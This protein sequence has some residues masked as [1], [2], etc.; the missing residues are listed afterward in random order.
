MEVQEARPH[1]EPLMPVPSGPLA[2]QIRTAIE[3]A[4]EVEAWLLMTEEARSDRTPNARPSLGRYVPS[5]PGSHAR[6]TEIRVL[7]EI[8]LDAKKYS[9]VRHTCL[10]IPEVA[11]E[12]RSRRDTVVVAISYCMIASFLS[13]HGTEGRLFRDY[14]RELA[15]VLVAVFPREPRAREIRER[16]YREYAVRPL[17]Q[18]Q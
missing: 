10:F 18:G 16:A 2:P 14:G 15:D 4:L 12:F 5:G 1:S 11:Y 6:W 17:H 13:Q 8:L 3:E 7:R 9:S